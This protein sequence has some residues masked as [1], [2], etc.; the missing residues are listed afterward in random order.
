M[1]SAVSKVCFGDVQDYLDPFQLLCLRFDSE[2]NNK[3]TS[4]YL[5]TVQQKTPFSLWI[6]YVHIE[7]EL[8]ILSP[9]VTGLLIY[10][11]SSSS[12][13]VFIFTEYR[14]IALMKPAIIFSCLYQDRNKNIL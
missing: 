14:H 8:R 9:G 1:S 11:V 5:A 4:R 7:I 3:L 2:M 13:A 6:I 12:W 10:K